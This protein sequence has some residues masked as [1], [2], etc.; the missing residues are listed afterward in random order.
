[1]KAPAG[2]A[3][4]QGDIT[5]YAPWGNLAI[6]VADGDGKPARALVW[7]GRIE[8]GLPALQRSGPL[9][10]RIERINE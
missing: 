10:V 1:M 2:V 8:S 9:S 7:L 3:G 5:F 6:F 4:M